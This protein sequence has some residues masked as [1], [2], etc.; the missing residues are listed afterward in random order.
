MAENTPNWS[1]ACWGSNRENFSTMFKQGDVIYFSTIHNAGQHSL[2]SKL[3][4]DR[5]TGSKKQTEELIPFTLTDVPFDAYWLG[6]KPWSKL[7]DIP[8][9]ELALTLNFASGIKLPPNY[10]GQYL[11]AIRELTSEDEHAIEALIEAY[12]R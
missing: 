6:K 8:F 9:R 5:F 3:I 7:F 2:F 11:Q 4:L 1:H 12:L 10:N